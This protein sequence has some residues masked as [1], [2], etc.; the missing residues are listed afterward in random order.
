MRGPEVTPPSRISGPIG[1][2][3]LSTAVTAGHRVFGAVF[4]Q[5]C[6][7]LIHRLAAT[8]PTLFHGI[9]R[10]CMPTVDR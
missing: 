7:H 8:S 3:S 2:K 1:E 9:H 6:E 4:P 5:L 10:V